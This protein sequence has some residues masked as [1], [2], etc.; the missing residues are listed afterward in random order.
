MIQRLDRYTTV[1]AEDIRQNGNAGSFARNIRRIFSRVYK[2]YV[3][4]KGYRGRQIRISDRS[5]RGTVSHPL[6]PESELGGPVKSA[7][8]DGRSGGRRRG[9]IFHALGACALPRQCR[10]AARHSR[11]CGTPIS[12]GKRRHRGDRGAFRR[13]PRFLHETDHQKRD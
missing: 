9:R 7:P 10:P 1:R 5:V 8:G 6:L 12:V 2:C 11:T 13:H 4:R 3:G